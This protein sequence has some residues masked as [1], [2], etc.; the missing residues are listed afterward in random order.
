MRRLNIDFRM[1]G[2]PLVLDL[3][4]V[5]YRATRSLGDSRPEL[6]VIV[7]R[8]ELRKRRRTAARIGV[9]CVLAAAIIAGGLFVG[10]GG[11]GSTQI[12]TAAPPGP[13]NPLTA[14][15]ADRNVVVFLEAGSTEDEVLGVTE[16]LSASSA[17]VD[18]D[19]STPDEV[20]AEFVEFFADDTELLAT[21]EPESMPI[22]IS[23]DSND[24][25]D[26]VFAV[27]NELDHVSAIVSSTGQIP[28]PIRVHGDPIFDLAASRRLFLG[29]IAG[30]DEAFRRCMAEQGFEVPRFDSHTGFFPPEYLA[31][32]NSGEDL[33]LA[34]DWG[35]GIFSTFL[36]PA[37]RPIGSQNPPGIS[38]S[39]PYYRAAYGGLIF[40]DGCFGEAEETWRAGEVVVSRQLDQIRTA[41]DAFVTD[42]RVVEHYASWSACMTESGFAAT[43]PLDA[44]EQTVDEIEEL[45]GSNRPSNELR[46]A[47]AIEIETAVATVSCGGSV[48]SLVSPV[49]REVWD[50][51]A[52]DDWAT[53]AHHIASSGCLGEE[54]Y[55]FNLEDLSTIERSQALFPD[56]CFE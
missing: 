46:A 4:E 27:L 42:E 37:A 7:E 5:A 56:G 24:E 50:E 28:R 15:P 43:S 35:F 3:D 9:A 33:D 18:F 21:I 30:S 45:A 6:E 48:S 29:S 41:T 34:Q 44:Y 11:I 49:L 12:E 14:I 23:V 51:Y 39:D 54:A 22:R 36:E 38:E 10:L 25:E 31:A 19:V 2:I 32:L 26:A 17:I 55:S 40:D 13:S 8:S 53:A 1:K 20:Y 16:I 52:E 47:L